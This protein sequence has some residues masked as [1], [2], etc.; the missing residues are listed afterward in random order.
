M[1][2]FNTVLRALRLGGAGR[3]APSEPTAQSLA[4]ITMRPTVYWSR[5]RAESISR[6]IARNARQQL[7][8]AQREGTG[9]LCCA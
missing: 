7:E 2:S 5:E 6:A 9:T 4:A 8:G 3:P 1:R